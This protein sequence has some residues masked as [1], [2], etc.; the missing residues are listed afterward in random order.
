MQPGSSPTQPS[1][2]PGMRSEPGLCHHHLPGFP[3]RGFRG[4][5]SC[6][7]HPRCFLLLCA[8][9]CLQQSPRGPDSVHN[10][11]PAVRAQ[12]HHMDDVLGGEL[13]HLNEQPNMPSGPRSSSAILVCSQYPI[14]VPHQ[15][16]PCLVGQH[17]Y[18]LPTLNNL[19]A[20]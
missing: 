5:E 9:S 1:P 18:N 12:L 11:L 20:R 19:P 7:I 16:S 2:A 14:S 10:L 4:R 17:Q 6:S 15:T 8:L 3:G 13:N